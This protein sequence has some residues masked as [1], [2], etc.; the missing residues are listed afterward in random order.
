MLGHHFTIL[1]DHCALCA[2]NM[3]EPKNE[4][5]KRWSTIIRSFDF[6]I[7]Y[8]K[9]GLHRDVDCISRAP[10]DEIPDGYIDHFPV[11]ANAIKTVATLAVPSQLGD[12]LKALDEDEETPRL[13][14]LAENKKEGF[15][16][17]N[18]VLYK[19]DKL[20]VPTPY[21]K[22]ILKENHDDSSGAHGGIAATLSRLQKRY[23]WPTMQNDATNY[24][25]K[26]D[27]C[28]KRKAERR[29]PSGSMYHHQ[30]LAPMQMVAFDCLGPITESL[31]DKKHVILAIDMFSRFIEAKAV[32]NVGSD[33]FAKFSITFFRRFG[34]PDSIPTDN[35]PTFVNQQ[36]KA[37]T[38]TLQI[39]HFHSTPHHSQGNSVAERA[40]QSLQEKI[41]LLSANNSLN[42]WA[43]SLPMAVLALNTTEHKSVGYP[44]FTLMFG[45]RPPIVS[46][47]SQTPL[48]V[49]DLQA[50]LIQRTLDD[51]RSE[52]VA[53]QSDTQLASRRSYEA[54]HTPRSFEIGELAL[55]KLMGRRAKLAPRFVGPY[56][57]VN[58]KNDVYEI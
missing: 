57:I 38:A 37:L 12:W 50:E 7:K 27:T 5:L 45:R 6:S 1:T 16:E 14:E 48:S 35:A 8:I 13:L 55:A 11:S 10:V 17:R 40:V 54:N 58:K 36:I 22:T 30:V 21:R 46:S 47:V 34:T 3:K 52:A 31:D 33:T 49:Y 28:L 32:K 15:S 26:C 51:A 19:N 25:N 9:G 53:R 56:K 23:W 29:L 41:S 44:P 42:E 18:N 2:L 20:V 24:V 4:R 43:K 39:K